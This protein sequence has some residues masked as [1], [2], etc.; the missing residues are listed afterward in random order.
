MSMTA[1]SR[2]VQHVGE[3]KVEFRAD[4]MEDLLLEM[5]RVLAEA[6][7]TPTGSDDDASWERVELLARDN[8]ALLVDWANELIGRSEITGRAYLRVRN[9]A[10]HTIDQ[11]LQLIAEV[12][13]PL[14]DEWVSPL[15]AATYHGAEVRRDGDQWR[16]VVLFDV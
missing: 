7:G 3:W 1:S 9:L 5:A 4:T 16:A 8:A 12:C 14:V 6:T 13:G 11:S 15:K 2:T 10:V